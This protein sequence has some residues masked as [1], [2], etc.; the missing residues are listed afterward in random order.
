M[1]THGSLYLLSH[2]VLQGGHQKGWQGL[3]EHARIW[4]PMPPKALRTGG[5]GKQQVRDRS[6]TE[7]CNG[8]P[9][10]LVYH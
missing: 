10:A 9:E 1:L 8:S 3:V 7:A 2:Y 6:H 5:C 4:H